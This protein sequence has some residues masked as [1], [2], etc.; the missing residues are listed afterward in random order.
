MHESLNEFEFRQISCQGDSNE[1]SQHRF[2][3]IFDK[4]IFQ[5]S[6]IIEYAHDLFFFILQTGSCVEEG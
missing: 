1:H 5:L 6:N 4:I 2:L 3:C